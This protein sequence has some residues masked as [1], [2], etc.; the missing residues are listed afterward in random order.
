MNSGR[1]ACLLQSA[2]N[3]R[4]AAEEITIN[5]IIDE[6]GDPSLV[7]TDPGAMQESMGCRVMARQDGKNTRAGDR[8]LRANGSCRLG[9][10]QSGGCES[11]AALVKLR[12]DPSVKF[13]NAT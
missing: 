10:L 7:R 8:N 12:R 2:A 6:V 9:A 5:D 13:R 1:V 4:L 3:W 11:I